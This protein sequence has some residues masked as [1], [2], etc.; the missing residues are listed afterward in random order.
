VEQVAVVGAHT[1][2]AA[3]DVAQLDVT[4]D[5]LL[6]V[7]ETYTAVATVSLQATGI[8]VVAHLLTGVDAPAFNALEFGQLQRQPLQCVLSTTPELQL[9]SLNVSVGG[10]REV[11]ASGLLLPGDPMLDELLDSAVRQNQPLLLAL[12]PSIV[13]VSVD[14]ESFDSSTDIHAC[15]LRNA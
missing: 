2:R 3:F 8:T 9:S 1:L 10:V 13:Q 15:P 14:P 12:A 6:S 5:F 7:L 11:A 4:A